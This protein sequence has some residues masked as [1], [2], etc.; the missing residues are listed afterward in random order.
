MFIDLENE[1]QWFQ[2]GEDGDAAVCLRLCPLDVLK[3]ID[4]KTAIEKVEYR[5][6]EKTRQMERIVYSHT[7]DPDLRNELYWDYI[8]VDFRGIRNKK[9][10]EEI[11]C[12]KE[13]KILLMGRSPQFARFV[14]DKIEEMA[15][16]VAVKNEE[17]RK[18]Y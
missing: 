6:N 16:V 7:K 18:N 15:E 13:N 10:G 1:G 4:K 17:V 14:V 2:F 9:T 12:T 11:P 3:E 5:I 8:I